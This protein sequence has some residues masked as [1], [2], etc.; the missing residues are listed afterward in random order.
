MKTNLAQKPYQV[1]LEEL[2]KDIDFIRKK[3]IDDLGKKDIDY[4]LGLRRKSRCLEIIGRSLIWIGIDPITLGVG[5]LC[6]FLHRN[7]EA[8][9]LGHNCLHGQYDYFAEIPEFHS[10]HF[11][12]KAPIDEEGWRR[13]HNGIHHV[14]SNVYGEDPDLNHG[15][16]R[17]ND[18][19]PWNKW[20]LAQVPLYLFYF[21]PQIMY[22]FNAQN[23][24]FNED[25]RESQFPTGNQGYAQY[26]YK[27]TDADRKEVNIRHWRSILRILSKEYLLFPLLAFVT[28]FS[29]LKVFL[30]NLIVDIINNYWMAFTLQS[31]HFTEPLQ[32][33]QTIQNKGRWYQSQIESSINFKA[34]KLITLM[35]G[36]VNYQIEHH[37]FADLPSHRYPK[38]AKDVQRIC[39]KHN[40]TY[41]CNANW[42]V[43]IAR[44]LKVFIKYSFPSKE[45]KFE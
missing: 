17:T 22:K 1:Q 24:G 8:V 41:N 32:E 45:T 28:G 31:S 29:F 2:A 5:G 30:M 18:R 12:W 43:A 23:L 39:E 38:I 37:L 21:Y 33:S 40:L 14:H 42:G 19:L 35:C 16:L 20:H 25:F 7:I 44:Y 34:S 26:P 6:L 36:H 9:E 4:I 3:Q 10:H 27:K 15:M 13:E 11:K